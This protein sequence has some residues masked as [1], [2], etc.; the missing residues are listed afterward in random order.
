MSTALVRLYRKE[1]IPFLRNNGFPTIYNMLEKLA[2]TG[3][4]PPFQM[5]GKFAMYTPEN[6]LAW[7]EARLSPML[8]STSEKPRRAAKSKPAPAPSMVGHNNGPALDPAVPVKRPRGRP[9]KAPAE[10]VQ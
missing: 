7:A 4:G 1:A 6:L 5:F 3:G 9:R 8:N 2:S 10:A